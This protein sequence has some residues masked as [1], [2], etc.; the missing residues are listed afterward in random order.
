MNILNSDFGLQIHFPTR[1]FRFKD[2]RLTKPRVAAEPKITLVPY[3]NRSC[4]IEVGS[5]I[6]APD[7]L[8]SILVE[9][10][11]IG[12]QYEALLDW[13]VAIL[14]STREITL[15]TRVND[16]FTEMSLSM[17]Q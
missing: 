5:L 9:V 8:E 10:V 15:Y 14:I 1:S 16:I 6:R 12:N 17:T 3:R 7:W 13:P 2:F 11:T 4:S